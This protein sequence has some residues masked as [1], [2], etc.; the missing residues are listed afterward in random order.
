MQSRLRRR[1]ALDANERRGAP[2]DYRV[3]GEAEMAK[4]M[5]ERFYPESAFGGFTDVDGT[6]RFHVRVRSLVESGSVVLDV[7]CGRGAYAESELRIIRD[8][9]TLRG[10]VK[11]VIGI[12]VDPAAA[13]NPC[14]D[15]FRLLDGDTW[16]IPDASVDV[17]VSDWVLEHVQNPAGFFAECARVV[18][19]GGYICLRTTNRLGYV[20]V[21]S[22]LVPSALHAR[23]LKSAQRGRDERDVFPA[24]YRCN[25]ARALRKQLGTHGFE[26]CVYGI[27]SEPRYLNFSSL[28]YALGVAYQRWVP[29]LF[30]NVLVAYGRRLPIPESTTSSTPSGADR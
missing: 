15:E 17:L 13:T 11:H 21:I 22:R 10:A 9:R 3:S 25:T 29:R 1:N 4:E 27:E 26:R 14:I 19:P 2:V 24:V 8:L 6:I 7:G 23:I 12:D 16:P 28:I 30:T 18:R 20:S 5:M